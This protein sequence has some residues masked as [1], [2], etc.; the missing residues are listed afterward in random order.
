MFQLR[1]G[2]ND[3]HRPPTEHIRR[4]HEHRIANPIRHRDRLFTRTRK[5]V[6]RL[7]KAKLIDQCRKALAVFCKVNRIGRCAKNGDARIFQRLREFE[8]CLP[9]KLHD[10]ALQ[11]AV[12][13]LN[14][15]DFKHIFG[16]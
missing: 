16:G 1:L 8:R 10:N 3:F 6:L 5:A 15:Q 14:M 9:A 12:L 2:I 11:C 7:F 13:L 4:P